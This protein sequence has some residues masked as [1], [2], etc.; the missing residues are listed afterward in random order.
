MREM[1]DD[2]E[3]SPGVL[4]ERIGM[5][6]GRVSRLVGRLVN[7]ELITRGNRSDDRRNREQDLEGPLVGDMRG[8][9]ASVELVLPSVSM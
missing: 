2:D 7:K 6:R 3:T 5:T 8:H 4:A 1:F 9:I